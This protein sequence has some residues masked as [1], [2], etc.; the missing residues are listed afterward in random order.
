MSEADWTTCAD[1]LATGTLKDGVTAGIVPPS[2]GGSFVHGFNSLAL[3]TGARARFTNQVDFAPMALGGSIRGVIQRG[4][5][6]GATGFSPFLFI[7]AQGSSVNDLAYL[8]GLSDAEPSKIVLKKGAI[9]AG[10]PD[11]APDP[12]ANGI[13][14]RSTRDVAIGE[15]VHIRLDMIVNTN[16]DVILPVF[17]NDLGTNPLGTAPD[18]QPVAGMEGPLSDAENPIDG[19]IDDALAVASGSAPLTSGRAGFG[20]HVSDVTRRGYFD[21]IEVLR[22]TA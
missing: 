18:W 9:S 20:M 12:A 13:L 21:H 1:S 2:G 11:A 15:W 22:Q 6:G 14:L 19:F 17:E 10:V 3:V 7:G 8:I 5:S 4:P 16:G